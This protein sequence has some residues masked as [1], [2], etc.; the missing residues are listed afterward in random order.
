[1][2]DIASL[3]SLIV[4]IVAAL[5]SALAPLAALAEPLYGS[6]RSGV[7]TSS[8]GRICFLST[9]KKYQNLTA[10]DIASNDLAQNWRL[11]SKAGRSPYGSGLPL[12]LGGKLVEQQP[13]RNILPALART[14]ACF[15]KPSACFEL[16]RATRSMRAPALPPRAQPFTAWADGRGRPC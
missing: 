2:R 14:V 6:E 3:V 11:A 16:K 9:S 10:A 1:M 8:W 7:I 13:P 15:S 5:G 4:V 12:R